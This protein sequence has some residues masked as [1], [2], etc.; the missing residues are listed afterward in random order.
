MS[1][2]YF[3]APDADAILRSPD[4]K[5]FR[6]HRLVLSLASPVFQGMFG[7]PQSTNN[8]SEIPTIDIPKSSD[9]LQPFIQYLY[10]R[11]PPKIPDIA[12]WTALYTITD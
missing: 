9:I 1:L 2:Y 7:L 11:P 3:D 4:G 12:V 5:E 6:V 10:P 8:P